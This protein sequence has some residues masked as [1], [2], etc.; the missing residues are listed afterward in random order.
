MLHL[1]SNAYIEREITSNLSDREKRK[2]GKVTA[3]I[4]PYE[5]IASVATFYTPKK[6][7]F[8][9]MENLP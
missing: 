2:T 5:Q 1:P 4:S 7:D 9:L 3:D 6:N 8:N